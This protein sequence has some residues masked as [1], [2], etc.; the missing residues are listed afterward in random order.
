MLIKLAPAL[1]VNPDSISSVIYE[2]ESRSYVM[3]FNNR[4]AMELSVK[5]WQRIES[6]LVT[7]EQEQTKW[8]KWVAK[9]DGSPATVQDED[10]RLLTRLAPWTQTSTAEP[11][12]RA[13]ITEPADEKAMRL[14]LADLWDAKEK[15]L[16]AY[17][18]VS[19][20]NHQVTFDYV[21]AAEDYANAAREYETAPRRAIP[22][23]IVEAVT[24]IEHARA[25]QPFLEP[26][27]E[28]R[29]LYAACRDA[30]PAPRLMKRED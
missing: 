26:V 15:A 12:T 17:R 24:A 14:R 7:S 2:P 9:R 23:A 19:I 29:D 25:Q 30:L 8:E 22:E 27:A 21:K 4:E 3:E 6:L 20:E 5:E 16:K 10:D 18:C 11:L 1:W 28:F 13:H